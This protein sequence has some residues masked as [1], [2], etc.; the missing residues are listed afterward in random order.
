MKR[1]FATTLSIGLVLLL[2][3]GIFSQTV[4][5]PATSKKGAIKSIKVDQNLLTLPCP[6]GVDCDG[7]APSSTFLVKVEVET[8]KT[9]KNIE[10]RYTATAGR[11]IGQGPK[12]V[13]DLANVPPGSYAIQVQAFRKSRQVSEPKSETVNIVKGICICDCSCPVLAINATRNSITVGD[14]VSVIASI[15][16]GS[17]D[18]PLTLNWTTSVGEI[19]SGQGTSAILI[20]V[21]AQTNSDKLIVTLTIGRFP[22]PCSACP[23]SVS[24]MIEIRPSK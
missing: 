9:D 11:I 19:L 6:P 2:T 1:I 7:P 8:F 14:S 17:Q 15:R 16:G 12:V 4:P 5:D 13:W 22:K 20:K 24:E 23:T 10:Y 3:S 18:Y 21:P